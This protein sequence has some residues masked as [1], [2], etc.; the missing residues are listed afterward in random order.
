MSS[1]ATKKLKRAVTAL[2]LAALGASFGLLAH[3][4]DSTPRPSP[5]IDWRPNHPT[6]GWRYVGSKTCAECHSAKVKTQTA[7]AMGRALSAPDHAEILRANPQLAFK[8]GQYTYS[9]KRDGNQ[10]IYSV[11]DGVNTLSVPVFYAFGI[12]DMGQTYV[13]QY[14]EKFYEGRVSFYGKIGALDITMGHQPR[15]PATLVEAMGREMKMDETRSCFGCHSTNAVNGMNLQLDQLIEGVTCEACHGPGEKHVAAMQAGDL[16]NKQIFNPSTLST[17][18]ISNFCGTCH[19]T[20]DQV[21]VMGIRGVQNVRFQ[22]YRLTNSK[23]YD[24]DDKRISCLACHDP[25]QPRKHD[26]AS[27]DSKCIAC[28]SM[29]NRPAPVA[30]TQASKRVALP[31]RVGKANCASC[32]MPRLE[33]PGSHYQ[34]ADH[35]IRIVKPNEPYP[36]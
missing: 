22:P 7:T 8:N 11:G 15:P 29:A 3:A 19:R 9:L 6:N 13:L 25:H 14:K 18:D 1:T 17:E 12:A 36:N 32:H 35:H 5:I 10:T 21:A 16:E 4:Q 30:L 2:F 34:F 23:C 31:C 24:S 27:Y 20:W 26:L 28:H 33:I